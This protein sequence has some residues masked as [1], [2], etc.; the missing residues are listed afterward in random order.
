MSSEPAA[1]TGSTV[2]LFHCYECGE[3]FLDDLPPIEDGIEGWPTHA[4][5]VTFPLLVSVEA[6]G[7]D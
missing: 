3:R 5:C 6:N 4:E 7:W 2:A 1:T